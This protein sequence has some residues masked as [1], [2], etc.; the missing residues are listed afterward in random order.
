M[1]RHPALVPRSRDHH[2]ALV[3]EPALQELGALLRDQHA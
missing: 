1:K 3:P 2:H